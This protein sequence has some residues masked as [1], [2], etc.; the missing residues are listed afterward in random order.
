MAIDHLEGFCKHKKLQYNRNDPVTGLNYDAIN[1]QPNDSKKKQF[2][3]IMGNL[4][5][6]Y[7]DRKELALNQLQIIGQYLSDF[8]KIKEF[9]L[10]QNSSTVKKVSST[11]KAPNGQA[12]NN[13]PDEKTIV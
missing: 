3:D 1:M 7:G 2:T 9:V 4:F 11:T 10:A 13:E 5:D 12:G 8:E 6:N